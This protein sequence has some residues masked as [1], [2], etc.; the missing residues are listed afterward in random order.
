MLSAEDN[1][2]VC[3][4]GPG[5][6]MGKL[7]REYWLPA[8]LS[9][10]L[11]EADSTPVRLLLLGERFVAFRDSNGEVG[12]MA[13]NCPHRGA[14]LFFGRVEDGGLRCGYHGWKFD[15]AG[16]CLDMPNEPAESNFKN[17]VRARALRVEERG[18]IIWAYLGDRETPPPMPHFDFFDAPSDEQQVVAYQVEC[19]WLQPVEGDIDTSH[20][21][22]LHVGHLDPDAAPEGSFLRHMLEDRAPRYR[23]IDT[24]SGTSYGAYRPAGNDSE[25]YWRI[26]HFL[27]PFYTMIPVGLLGSARSF[28]ARVPMDDTH[29]MVFLA[30]ES[31][32]RV[33]SDLAIDDDSFAG[34]KTLPNT[35]DWYGRFKSARNI[36]NDFDIDRDAQKARTSW[37]GLQGV[38]LEDRAMCESMGEIVERP[39]EH[40]GSADLMVI[41]TRRRIMKVVRA[42]EKDGTVPPGVDDPE[43]YRQRSGGVVLPNGADWLEGTK[44]FREGRALP[45]LDPALSAGV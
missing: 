7:M 35:T 42:H 45:D 17:K 32:K 39:N 28:V 26:A 31:A 16:T 29:T 3:R 34:L 33:N 15:R 38:P 36:G 5:T 18:G 27:M 11:P 43:A 19:N 30:H 37:S 20:F 41:R 10:E 14:S 1:E 9:S 4:T 8:L 13:H 24:P 2:L 12:I 25:T 6:P 23:V 40:L 21:G 44:E 22:F